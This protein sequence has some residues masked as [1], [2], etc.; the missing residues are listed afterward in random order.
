MK[1]E[2]I[3]III[4]IIIVGGISALA[5][6]T[7][8]RSKIDKNPELTTGLTSIAQALKDSGTK[9]YG[10]SWCPHCIEQKEFFK[11]A[12]KELPYTECSTGGAGSPQTQVCIDAK[13][14]SY[15]T[16]EFA[17]GVRASLVFTPFDLAYVNGYELNDADRLQL[18]SQKDAYMA[19]LDEKE[20]QAYTKS[21]E[22]LK[23]KLTPVKK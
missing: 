18:Q 6:I 13:I 1:K 22:D 23:I 17:G 8:K 4:L 15:P 12:V 20:K 11:T 14:E 19:V 10:A 7:N 2:H 21:I 3:F 5:I 16:W 9:F